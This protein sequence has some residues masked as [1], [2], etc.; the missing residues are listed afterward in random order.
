MAET[1][2]EVSVKMEEVFA[3]GIACYACSCLLLQ[4]REEEIGPVPACSTCF[5]QPLTEKYA[6]HW[7]EWRLLDVRSP[8]LACMRP[9]ECQNLLEA[10]ERK[11]GSSGSSLSLS[12]SL[13]IIW[14]GPFQSPA[15]PVARN[16]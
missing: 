2:A 10:V 15:Y 12:P 16:E 1:A 11:E 4:G 8:R 3:L 7:R 13:G 14:P 9:S 6:P 5:T